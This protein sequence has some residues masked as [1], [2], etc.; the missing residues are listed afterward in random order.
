MRKKIKT[1]TS[2]TLAIL[3]IFSVVS[4]KKKDV[5]T[6]VVDNQF[7]LSL[8]HDTISMSDML[9]DM[10]S[11]TSGWLRAREDGSLVA[12][13]CDSLSDVVSTGDLL[14]DIDD[15]TFSNNT[16]FNLLSVSPLPVSVA[17]DTTLF[18]D[19]FASIPFMFDDFS[20]TSV[21]VREG[22]LSLDIALTPALSELQ[23]IVLSTDEIITADGEPLIFE[24][25]PDDMSYVSFDLANCTIVPDANKNV[26]FS[27]SLYISYN[28]GQGLA[29]GDFTCTLSGG[30]TNLKF[31]TLYGNIAK[32]MDTVFMTSQAI[33]FGV[34]GITGEAWL[35]TPTVTLSYDNTFGFGLEFDLNDLKFQS[36]I[37]GET[38]NLMQT[39]VISVVINATEGVYEDEQLSGFVP[40]INALGQY[41]QMDFGGELKMNFGTGDISV[42][43]TSKVDLAIGVE[44]PLDFNLTDLS[45]CDTIAFSLT[46]E[47][48]VQQYFNEI[49]F[50][51][52]AYN[53]IPLDVTFDVE[54]LRQGSH[55]DN[56]FEYGQ[57]NTI[58]Y[59]GESTIECIVTDDKLD[60]VMNADQIVLK[61]TVNTP[62]SVSSSVF[63]NSD[64]LKVGLRLLTKTNEI[65]V[66]DIL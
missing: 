63:K 37:T 24:I 4:C 20:V 46:E 29:G 33:D 11:T 56:L 27:G 47:N 51:I 9:K 64:Y 21:I 52:D 31:K 14:S 26:V 13:Y 3:M 36:G 40:Q 17:I 22:L 39:P 42:S 59:Q 25:N 5:K 2:A 53:M 54:F 48:Q 15:V 43:D 8:F 1:L 66:D 62:A 10:D 58:E 28:T 65:N 60:N 34:S 55:L 57:D 16:D 23:K 50:F 41:T 18:F 12:F 6:I 49:D 38:F 7:A 44:L 45:Y 30:L 19:D 32:S 35:P 61:I